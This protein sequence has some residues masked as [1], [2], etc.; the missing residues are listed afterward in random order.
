MISS[1]ARAH[2][3][4]AQ[5]V[6]DEAKVRLDDVLLLRHFKGKVDAI[7]RAGASIDE[8]TLVQPVDSK[9]D[10]S[11]GDGRPAVH[12]VVSIV[13][14]RVYA[15]FRIQGVKQVGSNR[16]ITS[17]TFRAVDGDMGYPERQVR[18]FAGKRIKSALVGRSVSG[19]SNPRSAVARSGGRLFDAVVLAD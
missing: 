12:V 5:S 9:Y 4:L 6:A 15:V 2:P 19:W 14:D 13:D 1:P 16:K 8:F 7:R 10:F 18:S 3:T 17:E 11:E